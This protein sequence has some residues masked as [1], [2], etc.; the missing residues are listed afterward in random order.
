M[1]SLSKTS[2]VLLALGL[3]GCAASIPKD[4]PTAMIR[5]TA[6][7]PTIF[8]PA[9]LSDRT[10][11]FNGLIKHNYWSEVSPI[12][13]HETRSDKNNQVIERLIPA[14]RKFAFMMSGTAATEKPDVY[15][16]CRV[17]FSFEP[18][19]G[20]Q[21]AAHLVFAE[22]RCMVQLSRLDLQFGKLTKT[23]IMPMFYNKQEDACN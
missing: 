9:C 21:Y 7:V 13:M 19:P 17:T 6:D 3:A 14:A 11:V 23:P 12:K 18:K 5:A 4:M 1:G 20:E 22:N 10:F 8:A 16:N 2:I 15:S